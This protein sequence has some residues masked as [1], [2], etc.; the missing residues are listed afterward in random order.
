MKIFGIK[1]EAQIKFKKTLRCDK[2]SV[3]QAIVL[4]KK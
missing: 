4:F 2:I 1:Y 3:Y